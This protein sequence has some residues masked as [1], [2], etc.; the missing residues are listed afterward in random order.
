MCKQVSET[1]ENGPKTAF[2]REI[3]LQILGIFVNKG[4][5]SKGKLLKMFTKQTLAVTWGFGLP[6]R[7]FALIFI[8]A[9]SCSRYVGYAATRRISVFG[10]KTIKILLTQKRCKSKTWDL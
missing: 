4:H 3:C 6:K 2:F 10:I 8:K 5:F 1:P 7:R 9:L